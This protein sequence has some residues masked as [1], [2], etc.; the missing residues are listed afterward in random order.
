MTKKWLTFSAPMS[1]IVASPKK[2]FY[3]AKPRLLK[4]SLQ[5]DICCVWCSSCF[6][7]LFIYCTN[8]VFFVHSF[9]YNMNV[10]LAKLQSEIRELIEDCVQ[11]I[12]NTENYA[13]IE[14]QASIRKECSVISMKLRKKK[15]RSHFFKGVLKIS[16]KKESDI[17]KLRK[18]LQLFEQF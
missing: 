12:Q 3:T 6:S 5:S 15:S 18:I 4:Y 16:L 8:V 2:I 13:E 14:S 1:T 17:H 7:F 9:D 11:N 10:K